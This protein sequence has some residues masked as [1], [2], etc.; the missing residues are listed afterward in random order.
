MEL[1]RRAADGDDDAFRELVRPLYPTLRRWALARTAD[2][3]E[4]DEV[5]QRTLIGMHGGLDTFSGDA[6]LSSWAYRI[7]SNA[8]VDAR[9]AGGAGPALVREGAVGSEGASAPDPVRTVHAE[10]IADAVYGLLGG[11][12]ARQRQVLVMVDHEGRRPVDVAEILGLKPVT[13]RANLFKARRALREAIL[14]RYPELKEG[15]GT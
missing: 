2:P 9:R 10:R 5:V 14:D 7:L 11:L 13:V 12:P 1:V 3:D 15:Y 6:R 8:A 4:A